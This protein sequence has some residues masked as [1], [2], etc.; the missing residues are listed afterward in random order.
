MKKMAFLALATALGL[1]ACGSNTP[2]QTPQTHT[3]LSPAQHRPLPAPTATSTAPDQVFECKN[4]MTLTVQHN[5]GEDKIRLGVNTIESTAILALA[6]SG[7]GE[8]YVNA[9]GF[10]NQPTE[11]H[12]KGKEGVF[13]F[14]DPYQNAVKTTCRSK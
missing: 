14:K 9:N 3:N 4:G 7:S 8:R 13:Q 11:F 10:Y 1:S 2:N 5:V 12:F 6:P